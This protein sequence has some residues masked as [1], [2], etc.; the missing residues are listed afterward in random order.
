MGWGQNIGNGKRN[1]RTLLIG[2]CI[3]VGIFLILKNLQINEYVRGMYDALYS[4]FFIMIVA[5]VSVMAYMYRSYFGRNILHELAPSDDKKDG[6]YYDP[7]THKYS[8]QLPLEDQLKKDLQEKQLIE[9]YALH[10]KIMMSQMEQKRKEIEM[11][12]EANQCIGEKNRVRAAIIIQKWWRD[13]L[14]RPGTGIFY[15]QSKKSFEQQQDA[16]K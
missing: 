6:W 1:C 3:Y 2:V 9:E 11:V 16:S 5:D 10:E 14:Y 4:A 7:I 13:H 12:N 8:N 15:L